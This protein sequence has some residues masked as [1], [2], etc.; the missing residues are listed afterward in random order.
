VKIPIVPL[1]VFLFLHTVLFRLNVIDDAN[2]PDKRGEIKLA[3]EMK[4]N[5]L[6]VKVLNASNLETA[7]KNS[8]NISQDFS[9]NI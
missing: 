2:V 1:F 6:K 9:I 5:E 7:N 8:T 4:N 3:V